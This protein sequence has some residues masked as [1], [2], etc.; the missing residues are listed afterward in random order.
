MTREQRKKLTAQDRTYWHK[1]R[2]GLALGYRKGTEGAAWRLREFRKG[3]YLERK[4]GAADD[5]LPANGRDVLSWDE[6]VRL[7]LTEER[8]TITRPPVYTLQT[9]YTDYC[10]ARRNPVNEHEAAIWARFIA[11]QLGSRAIA[12]L[13][14]QDLHEW[15]RSQLTAHGARRAVTGPSDAREGLRRARNTANRRWALLRSIL[16]FAFRSDAVPSDAAWR[17]VRPF[18]NVDRPRTVTA[19][20]EQARALLGHLAGPAQALARAALLTGMR[21]GELTSLPAGDVDIAGSRLRV[22]HTKSGRERWVP[23]TAEGRDFFAAQ[24]A[25]KPAEA[26]VL[27]SLHPKPDANRVAVSRA[28]RAAS[29]ALGIS[30]AVHFHDLRRSW[31]SLMLN[32]GASIEVIQQVLGHAD[33]RMTRRVY[34]HLMNDTVAEQVQAHLPSFAAK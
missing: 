27:E 14:P 5:T 20:V 24:I 13:T 22:R 34:A 16:N 17:K 23:L 26:L 9:A 31:G 30:P 10:A 11:P 6:A 3:R 4:L 12:G 21:L 18:R 8:P 25:G 7:A 2:P 15:L 32:A 19:S 1:L 28:M 33:S 29:A